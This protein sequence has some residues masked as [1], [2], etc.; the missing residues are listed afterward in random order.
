MFGS[1]FGRAIFSLAGMIITLAMLTMFLT[2]KNTSDIIK[3]LGSTF[4]S[5]LGTAMGK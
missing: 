3:T 2:S 5:S 4:S 1:D